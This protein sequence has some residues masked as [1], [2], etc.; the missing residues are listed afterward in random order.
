VFTLL[1]HRLVRKKPTR[2]YVKGA[3][4][5]S[6][7][8]TRDRIVAAVVALHEEVGPRQTTIKSIAERAGV[9]RLT[10]YRHFP[11]QRELIAACSA[12]WNEQQRPPDP[13]SEGALSRAQAAASLVALYRY[14]R[15]GEVMLTKVVAD[16]PFMPEV[17][18]VMRPFSDYLDVF[19]SALM[20]AWRGKSS[21]RG[22][23]LRHAVEFTTWQ[24]LAALTSDDRAA[25]ELVMRW[26]DGAA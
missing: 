7:A 2:T 6:E 12:R 17:Q 20:R 15:D 14:Y 3:R 18:E 13:P 19:A 24:S 22:V 16:A 8:E 26:C 21:R 5:E 25:A 4:A 9:Q 23:T 1:Y 10:V 11:G